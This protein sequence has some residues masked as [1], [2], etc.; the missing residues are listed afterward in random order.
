MSINKQ[1]KTGIHTIEFSTVWAIAFNMIFYRIDYWKQRQVHHLRSVL[2]QPISSHLC[3]YLGVGNPLAT[4][5]TVEQIG[6]INYKIADP[7]WSI[8]NFITNCHPLMTWLNPLVK[9]A[10]FS[11]IKSLTQ[12]CFKIKCN[13]F[14]M[15]HLLRGWYLSVSLS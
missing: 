14:F 15:L 11:E 1:S 7:D 12:H 8:S 5:H 4:S 6:S 3:R 13:I 9:E 10:F 2:R